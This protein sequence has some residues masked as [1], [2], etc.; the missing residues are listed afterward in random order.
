MLDALPDAQ[1]P[2]AGNGAVLG[3]HASTGRG[4]PVGGLGQIGETGFG[5]PREPSVG[6]FLEPVGDL[7]LQVG[8]INAWRLCAE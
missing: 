5:G 6:Q 7:A 3:P 1:E 8:S 2:C 4:A